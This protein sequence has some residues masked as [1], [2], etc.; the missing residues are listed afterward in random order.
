[1]AV[2]PPNWGT[3]QRACAD[4]GGTK[5]VH[6]S[7]YYRGVRAEPVSAT[8]SSIT[9]HLARRSG[10]A[11]NRT[12]R[13]HGDQFR[14]LKDLGR[15]KLGVLFCLPS[16]APAASPSGSKRSTADTSGKVSA[17]NTG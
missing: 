17:G 16:G 7:T 4:I 10:Q 9:K 12:A 5:P 14:D 13:R 2:R 3:I 6:P 11:R 1:M 8:G 15:P